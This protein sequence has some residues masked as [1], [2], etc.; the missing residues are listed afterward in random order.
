MTQAHKDAISKG[1]KKY[2]ANCKAKQPAKPVKKAVAKPVKK[3]VAKPVK[4]AVAKPVK[5]AVKKAVAKPVKKA[6]KTPQ[7]NE[8]FSDN[9]KSP[10]PKKKLTEAEIQKLEDEELQRKV[11]SQYIVNQRKEEARE[12]RRVEGLAKAKEK[13]NKKKYNK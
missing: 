10:T 5:K 3:A 11:D 9:I 2:H 4:K 6:F 8:I 13:R 7:Q 1:V 12:K